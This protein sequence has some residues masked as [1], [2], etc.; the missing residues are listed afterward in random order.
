MFLTKFSDLLRR[1]KKA[2]AF[3]DYEYWYYSYRNLYGIR[4]NP[5]NWRRSLEKKYNI[6]DIMVFANFSLPSLNGELDSI[7]EITNTIIATGS[8]SLKA[9][10]NMTDFVM[11][12]YIY[13]CADSRRDIG[14]YILF[15]GDGHFQSV[16]KYLTQ[17]KHKNVVM[18]GVADSFSK[19]LSSVANEIDLLPFDEE[20][21]E[22]CMRYVILDLDF[23]SRKETIIPT[24]NSTAETVARQKNLPEEQ[25]RATII[26]ML[27][28][29]Y[30]YQKIHYLEFGHKVKVI[31]PNWE[32]LIKDGIWN[33]EKGQVQ[34]V[35]NT[36][37]IDRR[38]RTVDYI[39]NGGDSDVQKNEKN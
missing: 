18:F 27:D 25:V 12:D 37:S 20:L 4:P 5:A 31:A 14:T 6:D 16:V 17:K 33:P 2:M 19:R 26:K 28:E 21:Y 35:K 29:G 24:I 36:D 11:L 1:R 38:Y 23:C 10:K 22:F 30:L 3:I 39:N 9:K 32:K 7:R 34:L 15:T 8:D 13:Q